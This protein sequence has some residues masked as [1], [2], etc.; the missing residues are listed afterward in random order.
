MANKYVRGNFTYLRKI[1]MQIK[2][3][4]LKQFYPSGWP[5]WK[6]MT[7]SLAGEGMKLAVSCSASNSVNEFYAIFQKSR[8]EISA[9]SLR[10]LHFLDSANHLLGICSKDTNMDHSQRVL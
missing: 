2:T 8:L 3:T 9:K 10:I 4:A 5:K 6:Q 7:R 1:L